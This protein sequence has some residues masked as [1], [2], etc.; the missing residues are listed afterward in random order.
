MGGGEKQQNKELKIS[1]NQHLALTVLKSPCAL[2][3]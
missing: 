2:K 1:L 3:I